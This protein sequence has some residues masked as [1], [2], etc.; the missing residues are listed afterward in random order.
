MFSPMQGWRT[1]VK[2][3]AVDLSP[4]FAARYFAPV[5][6]SS[7]ATNLGFFFN[8]PGRDGTRNA[9]RRPGSGGRSRGCGFEEKGGG[10]CAY[11]G[12]GL[13]PIAILSVCVSVRHILNCQNSNRNQAYRIS[14]PI[15]KHTQHTHAAPT[16]PLGDTPNTRVP[17]QTLALRC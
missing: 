15:F 13:S 14:R 7:V 2:M 5:R 8:T 4:F 16:L 3:P 10:M 12:G 1:C 6:S 11:T 17:P 9:A